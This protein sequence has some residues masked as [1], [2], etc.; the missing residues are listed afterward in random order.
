MNQYSKYNAILISFLFVFFWFPISGVLYAQDEV[1]LEEILSGF[2]DNQKSDEDLQEVIEGFDDEAQGGKKKEEIEEEEILEGFDEDTAAAEDWVS[3]QEYLPDF[4]S[5]DGYFKLGSSYNMYHHQAEGT[6][7][8]WHGLSRLRAKM[9]LELDA[10]FSE[11]W[12]ARVAGHGFYD[13][14]YEIQGRDNFTQEVLDENENELEFGE[15]WLLGSITDQLDLKA[16][17]QIVVWGK[18]D[19]IRI[20]DV[21][22]PLDLR[23]PGLTDLENLRLPVTMTKLDYF[24]WGLNLSGMVIHEVRYNKN[25]EFGSDFFPAAQ[26]LPTTES[27]DTGF[28]IDNTQYALALHGI[29]HGW[30]ASLYGAYFYDDTPHLDTDSGGDQKLKHARLKMVGGAFNIAT[31]N[32]LFKTEAAYLDGIRFFNRGKDFNRIDALVGVEYS[33]LTDMTLSFEIADRHILNFDRQIEEAPDFTEEDRWV[34]ALRMTRT[35]LN[36]TLALTI[37]AQTWGLSGDDGAL[38]RFTAEYDLTDTIELTGGV[39]FYKSGDLP[40]FK[41]VGE[42]DRLYLEIK[43]NF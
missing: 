12:Q 6:D 42:N 13:F 18:S 10:K 27:P 28:D 15:V 3:E 23:E 21:L 41:N 24:L 5:L 43:Y 37:L 8:E 19:N 11:S 34:S 7:T 38:Q 1:E 2:E 26:P 32:W 14:V 20:T 30:D 29:F 9:V 36:E 35:Y 4:L 31:G 22:N 33:G 40:R 17:R 16:G 39:V 25:P